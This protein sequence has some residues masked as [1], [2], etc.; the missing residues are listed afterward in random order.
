MRVLLFLICGLLFAQHQSTPPDVPCAQT[1]LVRFDRGPHWEDASQVGPR[2]IAY[3]QQQLKSGTV[4]SAGPMA[5]AQ[6]DT[7]MRLAG[8]D[9][10]QAE[11]ILNA[12]PYEREGVLKIASHEVSNG[13]EAGKTGTPIQTSCTLASGACT[14]INLRETDPYSTAGAFGGYA[15]PTIRQDPQTGTLWMAYSWPHTIRDPGRGRPAQVIDT[16]VSYSTDKGKT[17]TYKGAL[18]VA[19]QVRNPVTGDSDYT[20]HEVMNLLPQVVKGVTYWYGIHAVYNVPPNSGRGMRMERYSKRWQIAMAP[21]DATTGPMGLASAAPQY[22]GQS[23]NTEGQRFPVAL[24]LSSVDP[25]VSGCVQFYEPALVLSNNNLYLFLSC[26]PAAS[27]AAFYAVFRTG[28]PHEHA[29][30][31]KWTYV[32][33]GPTKFANLSDARSVSRYLGSGATYLTQMDIMPSKTPGTLLAVMTAA[34]NENGRKVSLGCVAAEMASLDPPKF[35]YDPQG[36]I[37]VDALITSPDSEPTGPGSCTYSPVS[38]TGMIMAHRQAFRAPQ[39]NGFFTFLM[40]SLLT[41]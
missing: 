3:I 38:A 35:V 15:D 2:H 21:G 9:W 12:D 33:Q 34:Y 4:L 25:E 16:H 17:W 41:P 6:P 10:K 5:G 22:L 32:R 1:T 11:A 23:I 36:Q 26:Q 24:D 28:S 29:P 13:C 39:N 37:Q 27:P 40:Q 14:E 31:W 30:D 7:V 8:T 20:A 18:Y 19:Q